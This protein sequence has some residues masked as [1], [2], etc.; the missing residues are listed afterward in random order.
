MSKINLLII[1]FGAAVTILNAF[2]GYGKFAGGIACGAI[3]FSLWLS[4]Y[5]VER[6]ERALE[7]REVIGE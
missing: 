5:T 1:T 2:F 4:D 3:C 6:I 7:K